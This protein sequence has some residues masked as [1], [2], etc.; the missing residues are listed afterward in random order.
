MY[1]FILIFILNPEKNFLLI[2]GYS[3][4]KISVFLLID[5]G[6]DRKNIGKDWK[7]REEISGIKL[8]L[9]KSI[10]K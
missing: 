1:H 8:N 7:N 6:K 4:F 9:K 5:I 2:F 3:V 10:R